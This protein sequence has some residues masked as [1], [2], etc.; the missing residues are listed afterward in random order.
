MKEND[1]RHDLIARTPLVCPLC[2]SPERGARISPDLLRIESGPAGERRK[3]RRC[4]LVCVFPRVA[5]AGAIRRR[6]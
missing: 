3:C 4:G 5:L 6:Q 2:A 1:P